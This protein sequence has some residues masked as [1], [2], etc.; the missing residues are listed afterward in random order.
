M[1]FRPIPIL[2]PFLDNQGTPLAGG[3]VAF[4]D[5]GTTTPKAVYA[6]EGLS[7]SLGATITLDS[8]GR[9][10]PDEVWGSGSYRIRLYDSDGVLIDEADPVEEEGAS[11]V[12]FPSQSGNSGKYL[13]TDGSVMSWD[14]VRQ[15]PD[16]TGNAN[17]ILG[18]DGENFIWVAKPAD[19]AAGA[20]PDITNTSTSMK[21]GDGTTKVMFKRG[22]DSAPASGGRTTSKV[23]S[24]G[25]TFTA[26]PFVIVN[27]TINA[28]TGVG[29][30]PVVAVTSIST[31]GATVNI[32]VNADQSGANISSVV[33]FEWLAFGVVAS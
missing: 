24:F 19:G 8:A 10:L 13:T 32:D 4:Y 25:Q 20:D 21:V 28:I 3:S 30:S 7:T 22:S 16:P 9:P 5:A 29:Y 31:T 27:P 11:G 15:L 1:A 17:K 12:T 26:A 14:D 23:I 33:T 6:E 18:T 2:T